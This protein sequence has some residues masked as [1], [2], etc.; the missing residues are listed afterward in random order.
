MAIEKYF[1]DI[2]ADI[3]REDF[4]QSSDANLKTRAVV[5]CGLLSLGDEG[6]F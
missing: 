4:V 5:V 2:V 3:G 1:F 6:L